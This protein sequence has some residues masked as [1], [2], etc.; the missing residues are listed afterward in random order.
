[1]DKY[2][3][4]DKSIKVSFNG[5]DD[6]LG[7]IQDESESASSFDKS[8]S[9]S[10]SQYHPQTESEFVSS[11]IYS[12]AESSLFGD[13]DDPND[14]CYKEVARLGSGQ[15]FGELALISKQPRAATIKCTKDTHFAI[16][17][18][19]DYKRAFGKI[20]EK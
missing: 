12:E 20:Q 10:G 18:K 3:D 14:G 16:L 1:M 15:S 8:S 6:E 13:L 2:R 9:D 11:S 5:S 19:K 7:A 17:G 4:N